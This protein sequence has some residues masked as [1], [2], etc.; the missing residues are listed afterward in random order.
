[1]P[2]YGPADS[3]NYDAHGS[4][5]AAYVNTSRGSTELCAWRLAVPPGLAGVAHRPSHEEVLLV[6]D[7]QLRATVDAVI[8][9]L[10]PGSVLH[11]P[12]GAQLR[13]DSGPDGGTAWVT[14]RS[15]LTAT[16]EDG[17]LLSPQ[18]AQ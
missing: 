9:D 4:T 16:T 3:T 10:T 15:G 17:T 18:W 7:G 1:V 11:V 8:T 12:A 5:F 14:T 6:L 2:A 13:I